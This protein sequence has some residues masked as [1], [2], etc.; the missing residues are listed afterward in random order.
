VLYFV[1]T[2]G[3][4]NLK[5]RYCG[6]SFSRNLVPWKVLYDIKELTNFIEEDPNATI[7]FYGGEPLL[8]IQ[9]IK[10]V[11]ERVPAK[12]FGIQTNGLLVEKLK[13]EY[14]KEMEVVLLSIDGVEKVTD[15]YRGRGVYRRVLKAAHYLSKIGFEGDLIARMTVSEKSDIYRDVTHLLSL[16]IF[17]HVHWQLDVIWSPPWDN[18]TM[19]VKYSYLP[20]ILRLTKLWKMS[21]NEETPLGIAPFLGIAKR[22]RYGGPTP[23]CGAGQDAFS[24]LTN[25]RILACP[26]AV[27]VSWAY[28]GHIKTNSPQDLVG[29]ISIGEPCTSCKYFRYCGGRCLYAYK[30]RYWGESGFKSICNI[31]K[32]TIDMVLNC[33]DKDTPN[34]AFTY[35]PF[36]NSIEIIP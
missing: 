19:W 7:I 35:P 6:G 22:A 36:N 3:Q 27:D 14:W 8:N 26:I 5:C 13:P 29:K 1:F 9:F 31:T 11:I 30:E 4:C 10:D 23:P 21:F 12:R 24:I 17:N 28:L 33:L 2:T 16:G 20:G 25:G 34:N 32:R 18:F 15:Y